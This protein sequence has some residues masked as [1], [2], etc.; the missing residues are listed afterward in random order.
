MSGI[1]GQNA[2]RDSG[3]VGA[4]DF[5]V[6]DNAI[7][8]PKLKDALVADFTEVVDTASDSL[9]LGDATDS[10]NTKRD[11]LQ[12]VLDLVPAGGKCLQV[13][14]NN[15]TAMSTGT[16]ITPGDDTIPA[17]TEGN[18]ILSQ[19]LTA[20]STDNIIVVQALVTW[21]GSVNQNKIIAFHNTDY[22]SSNAFA[23][24]NSH[25]ADT[26]V[27]K[28]HSLMWIGNAFTTNASTYTVRCGMSGAG[29]MTFNGVSGSRILGGAAVCSLTIMEIAA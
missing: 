17:I 2:G 24:S 29:T 21:E 15:V 11:T 6:S 19:A 9:L 13:V 28:Q 23:C 3:V 12:G 4:V 1:V 8:E 5:S 26:G 7:D 22:H 14:G 10:G 18:Q 20:S 16:T 25:A 27:M